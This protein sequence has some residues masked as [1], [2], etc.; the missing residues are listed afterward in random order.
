MYQ[1]QNTDES[2]IRRSY[3]VE[4]AS[5]SDQHCSIITWTR[6]DNPFKIHDT[7]LSCYLG[8]YIIVAFITLSNGNNQGVTYVL[9]MYEI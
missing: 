9:E 4:E 6:N 5:N 2:Y 3:F 7:A 8:L 1:P